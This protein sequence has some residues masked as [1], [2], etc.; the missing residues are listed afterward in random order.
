MNIKV[1]LNVKLMSFVWMMIKVHDS[2]SGEIDLLLS[3]N[4][5]I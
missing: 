4:Y 5:S 2:Q 3:I 1:V